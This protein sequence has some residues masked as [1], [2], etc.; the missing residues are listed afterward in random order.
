MRDGTCVQNDTTTVKTDGVF[1]VKSY[2]YSPIL[3][4]FSSDTH[5]SK[6][7]RLKL[8]YEI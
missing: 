7:W 1:S 5:F 4:F 6:W 2:S 8:F 3:T